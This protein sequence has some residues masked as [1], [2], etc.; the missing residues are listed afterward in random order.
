VLFIKEEGVLKGLTEK[1]KT[2]QSHLGGGA[3]LQ[4]AT[5]LKKGGTHQERKTKVTGRGGKK[6]GFPNENVGNDC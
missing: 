5:D 2:R 1:H 3:C 4:R 6:R